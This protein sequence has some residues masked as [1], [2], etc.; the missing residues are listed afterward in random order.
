MPFFVQ[1]IDRNQCLLNWSART[2]RGM[3]IQCTDLVGCERYDGF[4]QACTEDGQDGRELRAWEDPDI[5]QT[6]PL[7][8]GRKLA[9]TH[10]VSILHLLMSI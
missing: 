6:E 2:I 1:G 9:F 10:L 8:T 5:V 3:E 7:G 4:L